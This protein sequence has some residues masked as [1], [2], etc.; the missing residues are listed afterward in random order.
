M[1]FSKLRL[2]LSKSKNASSN[3]FLIFWQTEVDARARHGLYMIREHYFA[4]GSIVEMNFWFSHD[5]QREWCR[6]EIFANATRDKKHQF[7][8]CESTSERWRPPRR[9]NGLKL[10]SLLPRL[11]SFT[12]GGWYYSR[13]NSQA[14]PE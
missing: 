14:M 12:D 11:S 10:P 2:A 5:F 8:L 13:R 4:T 1:D 7:L 9:D 3:G 6:R